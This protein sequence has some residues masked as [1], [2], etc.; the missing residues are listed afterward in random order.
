MNQGRLGHTMIDSLLPPVRFRVPTKVHFRSSAGSEVG[1]IYADNIAEHLKGTNFCLGEVCIA[2]LSD[3]YLV[4]GPRKIGRHLLSS[5]SPYWY[6]A[7]AVEE[8]VPS[9]GNSGAEIHPPETEKFT[10][11]LP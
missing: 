2:V 9:P 7:D 6:D 4:I 8:P 10:M 11:A 5:L 1:A 3:K